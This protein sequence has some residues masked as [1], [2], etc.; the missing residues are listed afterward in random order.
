MGI[1]ETV[2]LYVRCN[3]LWLSG[4]GQQVVGGNKPQDFFT[5]AYEH[6][7]HICSCVPLESSTNLVLKTVW[8]CQTSLA[9]MAHDTPWCV[10]KGWLSAAENPHIDPQG[11][12]TCSPSP[13]PARVIHQHIPVTTYQQYIYNHL[14]L[15]STCA[16]TY[17][18]YVLH[19]YLLV[20]TL[21]LCLRWL[22]LGNNSM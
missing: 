11:P 18:K 4:C 16:I 15:A 22:P 5:K 8:G 17:L 14:S 7:Y 20:E 6:T 19:N 3:P 12:G 13:L 1:Y 10:C 2:Q 9:L 21:L